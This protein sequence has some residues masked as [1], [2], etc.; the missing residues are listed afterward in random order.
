V[1][2]GLVD[3]D[4]ADCRCRINMVIF[5][6]ITIRGVQNWNLDSTPPRRARL[7]GG[8]SI[9]CWVLIVVFGLD[10]FHAANGV[11]PSIEDTAVLLLG[12]HDA[13]LE[14]PPLAL[15]PQSQSEALDAHNP[16]SWP[17][18]VVMTLSGSRPPPFDHTNEIEVSTEDSREP[19]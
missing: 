9:R 2:Q 4:G 11:T 18:V 14:S 17:L 13:V 3:Q 15:Q 8:I 19:P 16:T 6:F 1:N 7:A 12:P 10:L 5:E